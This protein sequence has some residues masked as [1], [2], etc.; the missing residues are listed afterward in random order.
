MNFCHMLSTIRYKIVLAGILLL[1]LSKSD[2]WAQNE[3]NIVSDSL[4]EISNKNLHGD[5]AFAFKTQ[6]YFRGILPSAAPTLATNIGIIWNDIILGM[7]GGVGVDGRY[8]ETDFILIY[9]KSRFDINLEYYYNFTQGITDIPEPSG[10]FDFKKETTRGL[11]DCIVNVRLDKKEHWSLTSST[12]LFGRDTDFG[13]DIIG[14]DTTTIRTTQR[15]SQYLELEYSW[16]RNNTKIQ[17]HIGGSFSWANP[18]GPQFYGNRPGI[19]NIGGS[20]T[21]KFI[22]NDQIQ[23]PVKASMYMNTIAETAYLILSI[24]LIQLGRL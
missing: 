13:Q 6:N 23:I 14:N 3:N 8:Q 20:L 22:I 24:N 5:F 21:R 15:Y 7:Y 1:V 16:Y 4:F 9:K 2:I 17:A 12:F 18:S 11:L 19:N 10:L